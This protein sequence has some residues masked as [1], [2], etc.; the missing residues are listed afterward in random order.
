MSTYSIAMRPYL[1]AMSS[2][3]VAMGYPLIGMKACSIIMGM[4]WV[5]MVKVNGEASLYLGILRVKV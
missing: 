3:L 2:H 4:D 5:T 1:S